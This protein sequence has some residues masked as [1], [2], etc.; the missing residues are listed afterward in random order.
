MS[1]SLGEKALLNLAQETKGYGATLVLRG[2][3][4]GSYAKT[5][6]ALQNIILKTGQGFIIDPE[7]FSLF[8]ITA[9]PTYVLAKPFQLLAQTRDQT[10]LH[11]RLMGHVSISYALESFAQ[12]GD[13]RDEAQALLD[14]RG[15]P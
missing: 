7:L 9:V 8:F 11:D 14:K 5:V 15:T 4:E 6:Q 2:F 1:F 10:P 3:I 13:L 12:S